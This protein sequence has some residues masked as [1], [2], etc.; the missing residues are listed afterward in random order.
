MVVIVIALN[1]LKTSKTRVRLCC[2]FRCRCRPNCIARTPYVDSSQHLILEALVEYISEL[3]DLKE[4]QKVGSFVKK[5]F[6]ISIGEAQRTQYKQN[7][8]FNNVEVQTESNLT[9]VQ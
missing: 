3:H 9:S 4:Q 8:Q 6:E 1:R 2:S 7:I 5:L